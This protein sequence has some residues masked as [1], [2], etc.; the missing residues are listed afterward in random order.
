MKTLLVSLDHTAATEHTLAYANKLAVRWPAEIV[1]LYCHPAPTAP[2]PDAATAAGLAAE[3]QRLRGL[4]ERL[5]YQQLTR[6]DGRRIRYSYRVLSGCLHDHARAEA[7]RCGADMLVMGLEHVD[8]GREEAPGNHAAAIRALVNCPLLLVPPGRRPLPN[9]LVFS[10]DFSTLPLA[11]LPRASALA[12]AFPAPMELVQ[13]YAPQERSRRRA[14]KLALARATAQLTWPN[15]TGHLLEDDAPLEG[16]SDFCARM[17]AQLLLIAPASQ[18]ELL[19]YFDGCYT[20]T[21]AYH[22]RIPVLVLP[23]AAPA[24]PRPCCDQCAARAAPTPRT[25]AAIEELTAQS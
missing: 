3:E 17:Q 7:A 13:F 19:R 5:R 15:V 14:L 10:A 1:L 25:L 24:A 23:T 9:R 8:C 11:V 22:T 18:A 16:T 12:G 4:V 6:Q 20:A 2:L 21:R